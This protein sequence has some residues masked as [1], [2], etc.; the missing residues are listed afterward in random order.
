MYTYLMLPIWLAPVF[1]L[2][3]QRLVPTVRKGGRVVVPRHAVLD[4]L[5]VMACLC[6]YCGV[7]VRRSCER[8]VMNLWVKMGR[9]GSGGEGA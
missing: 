8:V 7:R 5:R 9:W 6:G 3:F 4:V 2:L 1:I